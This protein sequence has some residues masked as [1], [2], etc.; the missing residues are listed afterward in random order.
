MGR[1][2]INERFP[3]R[4]TVRW[5]STKWGAIFWLG[6][7]PISSLSCGQKSPLLH[8]YAKLGRFDNGRFWS[9]CEQWCKPYV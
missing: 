7:H 5:R 8:R 2:D 4:S 6:L 3:V 9:I 1:L